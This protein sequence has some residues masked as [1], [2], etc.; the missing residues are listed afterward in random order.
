[1]AWLI[2]VLGNWLAPQGGLVGASDT[3]FGVS[4]TRGRKP[5]VFAYLPGRRPPATG[6]VTD[7]PDIMVEVV[8]GRP[9]DARRDRIGKRPGQAGV[10]VG[11]Y[12]IVDPNERTLEVFEL[13]ADGRYAAALGAAQGVV[14]VPGCEGLSL[15]LDALW[16][17]VERLVG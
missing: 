15:D 17:E 16:G 13:G 7:P 14:A 10:G 6:L 2:R 9:K 1:V 5:D 8:S 11:L 3:R 4:S 12:W